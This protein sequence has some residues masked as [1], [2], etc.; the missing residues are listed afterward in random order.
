MCSEPLGFQYGLA[1]S[2]TENP[3]VM[4]RAGKIYGTCRYGPP[5]PDELQR[6]HEA[7]DMVRSRCM[8]WRAPGPIPRLSLGLFLDLS[9]GLSLALVRLQLLPLW[10]RRDHT[11]E[12]GVSR[13]RNGEC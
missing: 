11:P 8:P 4:G 5:L 2:R 7:E 9:P 1:K 13:P 10:P 3:Q 12:C 6:S